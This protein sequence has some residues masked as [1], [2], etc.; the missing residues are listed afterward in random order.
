M[1]VYPQIIMLQLLS[2]R[3]KTETQYE[4][5]VIKRNLRYCEWPADKVAG[6]D[7]ITIRL[8]IAHTYTREKNEKKTTGNAA[9]T[10]RPKVSLALRVSVHC[11]FTPRRFSS[12]S[13]GF[14]H[15]TRFIW[16]VCFLFSWPI[17]FADQFKLSFVCTFIASAYHNSF[18]FRIVRFCCCCCCR[19][20]RFTQLCNLITHFSVRL[21][22]KPCAYA[23]VGI[24]YGSG[25]FYFIAI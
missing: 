16:L 8:S 17:R 22:I 18:C 7:F 3:N 20:G 10:V 9:S 25:C 12:G 6:S 4:E 24:S 11:A 23:M 21:F 19:L 15:R 5:R 1:Y 13:F 2:W 14:W